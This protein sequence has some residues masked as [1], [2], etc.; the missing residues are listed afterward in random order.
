MVIQNDSEKDNICCPNFGV[1]E[2]GDSNEHSHL[3][4]DFSHA[5]ISNKTAKELCIGNNYKQCI[6]NQL[7]AG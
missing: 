2:C 7:E 3:V 5:P 1:I 4:C 6:I